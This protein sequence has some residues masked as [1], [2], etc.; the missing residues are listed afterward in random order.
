MLS[1]TEGIVVKTKEYGEADLIVT[2]LTKDFG[3]INTFAKS[4]RRTRSRFGSSLEPLTHVKLSFWGREHASLPRLTQ[5]D[6]LKPFQ[7]IR[8]SY[9]CFV[10]VSEMLE[11][12]VR[13][14]PERDASPHMFLF[15]LNAL[16]S[17]ESGQ[18][19]PILFLALKIKLLRIAGFAPKLAGCARCGNEG[20][21]YFFHEGAV[22]CDSC[23]PTAGQM[24]R[25][26]QGAVRLYGS[27]SQWETDKIARIKPGDF[28]F[29]ELT[30]IIE[31]HVKYHIFREGRTDY[32][33]CK[34]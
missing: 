14:S 23:N 30:G 29:K 24:Q 11:L 4:P 22:M 3:L 15:L 1:R 13:C 8:E 32:A 7:K 16:K 9:D 19:A 21:M 27:L 12:L 28:L 17:V 5:S 26:S 31:S 33:Q 2:F 10:R 34:L 25:I 18:S 20:S 6:I